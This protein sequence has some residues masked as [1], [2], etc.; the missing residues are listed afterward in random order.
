MRDY[1]ESAMSKMSFGSSLIIGSVCIFGRYGTEI[2]G[3]TLVAKRIRDSINGEYWKTDAWRAVA[4]RY[5]VGLAS[6]K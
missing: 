4:S 5:N 3:S 1:H 6:A 2:S